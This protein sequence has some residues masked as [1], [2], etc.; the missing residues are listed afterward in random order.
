MQGWVRASRAPLLHRATAQPTRSSA[1]T[2]QNMAKYQ[3][4]G[5]GPCRGKRRV[6]KMGMGSGARRAAAKARDKKTRG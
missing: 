2:P 3:V 4:K 5:G 1:N 6:R